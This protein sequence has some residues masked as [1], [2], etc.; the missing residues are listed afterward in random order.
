MFCKF[1]QHVSPQLDTF[2][3]GIVTYGLATTFSPKKKYD[4][5]TYDMRFA[6]RTKC[7]NDHIPAARR[8]TC[9]LQNVRN[10]AMTTVPAAKR[11]KCGLHNVR[12]AVTVSE[13]W[14]PHFSCIFPAAL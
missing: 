4:R 2:A 3:N 14:L 1:E 5:K 7:G 10:A 8:M 9:G 11:M 13:Q 6:K 12:N